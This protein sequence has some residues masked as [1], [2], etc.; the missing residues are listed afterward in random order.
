M[1]MGNKGDWLPLVK[2][3]KIATTLK[4]AD[5]IQSNNSNNSSSKR[6]IM[7]TTSK[8]MRRTMMTTSEGSLTSDDLLN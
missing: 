7:K 8:T 6:K 5:L 3:G 1:K 2:M 4:K